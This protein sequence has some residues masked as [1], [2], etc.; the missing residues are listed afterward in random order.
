MS[1]PIL[2]SEPNPAQRQAVD[3]TEGPLLI[4]AGPG[5]GKTKTLVDRIVRLVQSGVLAENILVATF[6]EKAARELITRVSNQLLRLGLTANL[7]EMYIGTLHSIFL[8]L[9]EENREFTR[10]KRSYRI[11]DDFDQQFLM[12]RSMAQFSEI[13]GIELLI[14]PPTFSRWR[15]ASELVRL[16]N[17]VSEEYLDPATLTRSDDPAVAV[18][19]NAYTFYQELL[20]EE[21]VLDF[22]SIQTELLRMLENETGVLES[23][24]A[25]FRYLMID[26]Y[27]DT[28][29]I[30]ERIILMM[31]GSHQNLCV[32]G[33]DDQGLYRFRGASIRNILE[34]PENFAPGQCTVIRLET[35]YRSHP[36]II[37]FYNEWMDGMD[38][39]AGTTQHFRYPKTIVPRSE[40]FHSSPSVIKVG[41]AGHQDR[42]FEE[43]AAFIKTLEAS[44]KITDYNQVA[45]LFRSVKNEQVLD[46]AAFLETQGIPVFSPRSALFFERDE[47]KLLLGA[48][49][50]LFPNLFEDLKWQEGANLG[51]WDNY[52]SW[53]GYFAD[54]LRADKEKHRTLIIWARQMARIHTTLSQ[55]TNYALA[56]LL[57]QL[58]EFPMFAEL[59]DVSL[60]DSKRTLRSAYNIAL[61]SKILFRFE[62]LYNVTVFTA[63]NQQSVLQSFFNQYLRFV[64]DGGIAEYEDFDEVAPSG[65]VSFLTIHQAKGLEFPIVMVGSLNAVPRSQSQSVN[66][67]PYLRKPPFEPAAQTHRFDFWRLYYTAFSRAQNLL[68][69]TAHERQGRGRN[70]SMYLQPQYDQVPSWRSPEFRLEDFTFDTLKPT[71]IKHEYSFTS[72]I[73]LY[74]NCP[75]QYKFYKEL[76]FVEV[77]TGG[78][79]GGSLLHQTI[80]DIHRAV[81]RG[82]PH[83]SL[84]DE[85]IKGWYELNY[86][87]LAKQ[88]RNQLQQ[89]QL[90]ALLR[91]VL[92]YRDRQANNWHLIREA[93]VDVSLVKEDY[94]LKGT[95]DLIEGENG[96][97]ELVDFK[98][99]DKPDVNTTDPRQRKVLNQFRRQLEIYAHLVEER[100]GQTV[101]RMNLYFPKE[102]NG[103]PLVTFPYNRDN[104]SV[105]VNSFDDVVRKIEAYDYDMS[106]TIKT[107][108][109]CKGCD[110]RYHCNPSKYSL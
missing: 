54:A 28:N 62:Y 41:A 109:L 61:L 77:R 5:S 43:V 75:L 20:L 88:Q 74:E 48:I 72:H 32:V 71:N 98:S 18:L 70:P 55:H 1:E 39:T 27:Q 53:K 94:I 6:T 103:S 78:V 33:D 104:V 22:S 29:T 60:G 80:E 4:I 3:T 37:D 12:Y 81:L 47:I 44:G 85:R 35:N 36:G 59:L 63:K 92:R 76:E 7:N 73:L 24:R 10:L 46:L 25:R 67:T 49:I 34:F 8:R 65:C 15:R 52:K 11:L 30:Q 66:L 23:I 21:N 26:E 51:I 90:D 82:E 101:S 64:Y 45:M 91:Q 79:L 83:S 99:G 102:E 31:T 69:L 105:T 93:E 58:L 84:T 68:V 56:S 108:R 19:G 57:Y 97:V 107:E 2:I 89:G 14:G 106:H 16:L 42:Y 9:L 13:E 38:W 100:T 86:H 110:M 96:T 17:T 87:L 95:I 40:E 50:F